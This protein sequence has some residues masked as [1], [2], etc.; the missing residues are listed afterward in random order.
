MKKRILAIISLALCA[1]ML[2]ASCGGAS[3]MT[4]GT[5]GTQGTYYGY[6]SVLGQ[7]I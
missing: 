1:L 7:Y 4:M 6:G 3:K 5:G 2:L